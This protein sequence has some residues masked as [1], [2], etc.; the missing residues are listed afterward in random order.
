MSA[1]E[2]PTTEAL[3]TAEFLREGDKV[4]RIESDPDGNLYTVARPTDRLDGVTAEEL[5]DAIRD[6]RDAREKTDL[7]TEDGNLLLA[8]I[9]R[10]RAAASR[11]A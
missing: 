2:G 1:A 6:T 4:V 8:H 7:W 5:G 9:A 11:R 3:V 10:A